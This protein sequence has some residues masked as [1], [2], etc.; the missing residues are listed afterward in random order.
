M[1]LGEERE[2]S[3]RNDKGK[4][5]NICKSVSVPF[6]VI[7]RKFKMIRIKMIEHYAQSLA[8]RLR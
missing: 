3:V 2:R 8:L 4:R 7:R 5:L 6:E 1:L